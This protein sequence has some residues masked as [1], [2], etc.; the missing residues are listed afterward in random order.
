VVSDI[1]CEKRRPVD[2]ETGES[3]RQ[4]RRYGR[5]VCLVDYERE[6]QRQTETERVDSGWIGVGLIIL[7][8]ETYL[9]GKGRRGE[10]MDADDG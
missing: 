8:M 6:R 5:C 9:V 3:R 10:M 1:P 7:E 4:W 2:K